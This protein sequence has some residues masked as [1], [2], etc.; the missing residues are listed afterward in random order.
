[1][2]KSLTPDAV[3]EYREAVPATVP[4]RELALFVGITFLGI[5][6]VA[7]A[8][9][10][11]GEFDDESDALLFG[12]VGM[13]TP[14]AGLVL[15]AVITGDIRT[16]R[17][18]LASTGLIPATPWRRHVA[19]LAIGLALPLLLLALTLGIGVVAGVYEPGRPF[20][21][22]ALAAELTANLL[23]FLPLLV[24]MFGEEWGWGY[25]L[26]R[27]LPLGVWPGV[28]L[29]GLIWG[30]FHAPLTLQGYLYPNLPGLLG[31][32]LFTVGSVLLGCLMAWIR[33]ESGSLWPAVA[34]HGSSNL[35][36]N[37]IPAVIGTATDPANANVHT[38]LPGSWPSWIA[39]AIVIGALALTGRYRWK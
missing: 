28:L 29:S 35:L 31:T 24:L 15:T 20:P 33:M 14:A 32:L 7:L 11:F 5:T 21:F 17:R 26:P 16:P 37:P 6:A 18:W 27:L 1:M 13:F 39:M 23:T 10:A 2:P 12:G 22:D 19:Y 25:L 3:P 38:S 4:W 36:A 8:W 9:A 30:L 34:L